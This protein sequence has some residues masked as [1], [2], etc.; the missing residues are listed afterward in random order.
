MNTTKH[1]TTSEK[2]RSPIAWLGGKS[3]MV[4]NLRPLITPHLTYVEVFGGGASLLFGK[5]PSPVEVYNDLDSGL[6][7]F[8]R[9]LRDPDKFP[10]LYELCS[11]TPY[12]RE[13]FDY[14]RKTWQDCTDDVDRAYR[15]FVV[16]RMSF[17]GMFG[18]SWGSVVTSTSRGMASTC[19]AWLGIIEL[20]PIIH[21]RMRKVQIEHADFRSIFSRFD[22][23]D[24]FFYAD[25]PYIPETRKSGGYQ[26]ELSMDDHRELVQILLGLKGSVMLSGYAHPIYEPLAQ[27]GW[28]RL[29]FDTVCCV[30]GRTRTSGLKGRGNVKE[31]QKRV[32]SIWLNP[33]LQ[34]RAT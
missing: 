22:T 10:R 16:A 18:K 20:L 5:E 17:G 6:V 15:W 33:H 26:H 29:D 3:A 14:C 23:P 28:K 12:S 21:E 1:N 2:L 25:P 13:E 31:K 7:S 27:A 32:E 4:K 8:F 11:F 30:A 34:E 9:V 19:S 24:T